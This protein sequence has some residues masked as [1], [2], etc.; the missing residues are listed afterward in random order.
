[1]FKLSYLKMLLR[2]LFGCSRPRWSSAA[3]F[4][5]RMSSVKKRV[6]VK[7]ALECQSVLTIFHPYGSRVV[8]P[9]LDDGKLDLFELLAF[10]A[11]ALRQPLLCVLKDLTIFQQEHE[12]CTMRL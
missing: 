12:R 5:E 10:D 4:S 3:S 6:S 8:L 1:M 11:R 7:A 2:F 9:T